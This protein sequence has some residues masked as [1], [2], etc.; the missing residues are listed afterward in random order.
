MTACLTDASSLPCSSCY[1]VVLQGNAAAPASCALLNSPLHRKR[2][3]GRR[4]ED[5]ALR[6]GC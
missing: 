1:A 4:T 6:I 5:W 3:A 2:M